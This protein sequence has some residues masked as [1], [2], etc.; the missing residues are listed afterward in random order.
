MPL[1]HGVGV[2]AIFAGARCRCTYRWLHCRFVCCKMYAQHLARNAAAL[3][4]STLLR[5]FL[6]HLSIFPSFHLSILLTLP[7]LLISYI[8][9][10]IINKYIYLSYHLCA[11]ACAREERGKTRHKKR[12]AKKAALHVILNP[13]RYK[14]Q[15]CLCAIR[16]PP[17]ASKRGAPLPHLL[18]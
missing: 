18:P 3:L 12:A 13:I 11:H 7:Y 4:L 2:F 15:S 17:L 1:K 8:Y 6:F 16:L 5:V 10:K 9:S 14:I